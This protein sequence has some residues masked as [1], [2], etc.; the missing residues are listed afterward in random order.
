MVKYTHPRADANIFYHLEN[1]K[2]S[3]NEPSTTLYLTE[4]QTFQRHL[5]TAAFKLAGGVDLPSASN[6]HK[7][8]KQHII[9][10]EFL[11]NIT[12]AFLETIYAFLDGLVHLASEESPASHGQQAA[13]IDMGMAPGSNPLE[14]LDLTETVSDFEIIIQP[15][16]TRWQENRILLVVSNFGYLSTV[17]VPKMMSE[18]EGSINV[19]LNNDRQVRR[20][21]K[22]NLISRITRLFQTLTKVVQELDKTL[23]ESYIKPKS[24]FITSIVRGGILDSEMD[25]YDTPQPKGYP[26]SQT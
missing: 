4:I 3:P 1:W 21:V 2:S 15:T 7:P 10:Q 18:L 25:W 26:P 8:L 14:L 9:S 16:L 5:A 24:S 20:I 11:S 23:F 22:K 19:S 6:P 17:S 12:N 13:V